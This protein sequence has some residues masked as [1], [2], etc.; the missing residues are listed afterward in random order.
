MGALAREQGIEQHKGVAVQHLRGEYPF[1]GG[2]PAA[3]EGPPVHAGLRGGAGEA[4][5]AAEG[6]DGEEGQ[7]AVGARG[8]QGQDHNEAGGLA[9]QHQDRTQGSHPAAQQTHQDAVILIFTIIIT[10]TNPL[11]LFT[12]AIRYPYVQWNNGR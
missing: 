11:A 10:P 3:G 1:A 12:V 6:S 9:H 8:D 4:E 5:G 7:H 2:D